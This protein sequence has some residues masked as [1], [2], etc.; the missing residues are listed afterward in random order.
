MTEDKLQ[1]QVTKWLKSNLYE[2]VICYHV[3]NEFK[4]TAKQGNKRNRM[5]LMKG[6]PDIVINWQVPNH[7]RVYEQTVYIELKTPTTYKTSEKT[8]KRIIDIQGGKL[9]E[10]Q[11][12]FKTKCERNEIQY[13]VCTSLEDVKTVLSA[14]QNECCLKS[15]HN[16]GL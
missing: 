10:H 2:R 8:G 13:Y 9:S 14:R 16:G 12:D 5:G 4:G 11:I 6:V 3:A 1:M 7:D 15:F